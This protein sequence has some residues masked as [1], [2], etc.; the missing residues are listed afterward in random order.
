MC[1]ISFPDRKSKNN[2]FQRL[3]GYFLIYFILKETVTNSQLYLPEEP[4]N[5]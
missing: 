1:W 3:E 4:C 5:F 2:Y